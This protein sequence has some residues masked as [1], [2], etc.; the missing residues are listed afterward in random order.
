MPN[1]GEWSQFVI[2]L[3]KCES[4]R[5]S[6]IMPKLQHQNFKMCILTYFSQG[7]LIGMILFGSDF[8]ITPNGLQSVNLN[9]LKLFIQA[10]MRC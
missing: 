6:S 3:Y 7:G 9:I 4:V 10:I 8:R 1:L 2:H 5:C